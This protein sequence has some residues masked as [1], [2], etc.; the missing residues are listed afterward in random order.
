MKNLY[1]FWILILPIFMS[2]QA[3]DFNWAVQMPSSQGNAIAVDASFNVYTTGPFADTVDFDPGPGVAILNGDEN[4]DFFIQKLDSV[5]NFMW[6]KSI[7]GTGTDASI[8]ITIDSLDN[9]LITGVFED[10]VDFD[11]GPGVTQ[12]VSKGSFDVFVLKLDA[13]GNFLW[14][15]SWGGMPQDFPWGINLDNNNHV[16]IIGF[17]SDTVDFDPGP[18]VSQKISR[19]QSDIFVQKLDESGNLAWTA[20][21]GG[22]GNDRGYAV[23]TDSE[24]N[25]YTTGGFEWF[26]DFDPGPDRRYLYAVG[27]GDD[28]FIQKMDAG[29]NYMWAKRI[30]NDNGDTGYELAVDP[31]GN[32]YVAG[33]FTTFFQDSLDFDPGPGRFV[34]NAQG[35][36]DMFLLKLATNGDFIWARGI[37]GSSTFERVNAISL[38]HLGNIYSAGNFRDTV[39]FDSGPDTDIRVSRGRNDIFILKMG[40]HRQFSLGCGYRRN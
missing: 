40:T 27:Q 16:L 4:G 23:G 14:A 9:V 39:D 35:G 10:T 38:D 22:P 29:G 19:G 7:G 33:I 32:A 2:I 15:K 24:G 3:Q 30:G 6:A 26:A 12:L 37:G 8:A 17:F 18:G 5:G 25:V 11:P 28:V 13:S 36:R 34:L 1:L 31:Q 20:T 21:M